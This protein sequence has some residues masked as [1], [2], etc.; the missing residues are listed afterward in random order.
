MLYEAPQQS[1]SQGL[2]SHEPLA[3]TI[4]L[5]TRELLSSP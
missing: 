5:A 4:V 2:F 3:A 1:G